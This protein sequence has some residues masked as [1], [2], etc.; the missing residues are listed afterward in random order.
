MATDPLKIVAVDGAPSPPA[1]VRQ[2]VPRQRQKEAQARLDRRW[3]LYP[4]AKDVRAHCRERERIHRTV[5][6]IDAHV[7]LKDLKTLDV[8]CGRGVLA[9]ELQSRGAD[10][11][12]LD[13]SSVALKLLEQ[14]GAEGITLH[15]ET[16]PNTSLPDHSFDLVTCTDVIADLA[17][18]DYRLLFS[19]L[20]RLVTNE[21]YVV[22]STPLDINSEDALQRF[23]ALAGTE[24]EIL[25][26]IFSYHHLHVRLS[27]LLKPPKRF[28][29]AWADPHYKRIKMAKRSGARG[30]WFDYNTKFLPAH[31]WRAVSTVTDPLLRLLENNDRLLLMMERL[32]HTL[33][34]DS[35]TTH[36]AF[37]GKRRP[38]FR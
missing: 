19:E 1:A 18:A 31:C 21:G 6:L 4:E 36:I 25:D 14:D 33:W 29:Q 20:A 27:K 8:G 17:Q 16:L 12:A 13:A 3:L 23:L 37:I 7:V 34:G 2:P 26:W 15:Q 28:Y 32:S 22:C 38:L 11:H 10:I 5:D 24:F 9:R 35:A 30:R